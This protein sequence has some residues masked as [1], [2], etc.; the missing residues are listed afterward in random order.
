METYF[1][2][3][4]ESDSANYLRSL[5]SEF[6][7]VFVCFCTTAPKVLTWRKRSQI[8]RFGKKETP[9]RQSLSFTIPNTRLSKLAPPTSLLLPITRFLAF[10]FHCFVSWNPFP[11]AAASVGWLVV[12]SLAAARRAVGCSLRLTWLLLRHRKSPCRLRQNTYLMSPGVFCV[13]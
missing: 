6:L 10:L 2:E 3:T 8:D 7:R 9:P 11:S 4:I 13:V 5:D 1:N 12:F